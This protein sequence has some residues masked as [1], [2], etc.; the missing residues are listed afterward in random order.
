MISFVPLSAYDFMNRHDLITDHI[1][2]IDTSLSF[3]D[4]FNKNMD[5]TKRMPIMHNIVQYAISTAIYMGYKEIYLL[6]CDSTGII[7]KIKSIMH[8]S[9][10]GCYAYQIEQT[11]QR[12]INAAFDYHSIE[13]QFAGWARIF[14]LYKELYDYCLRRNI[15]LV[16]CS[17]KT[18]IEGIPQQPLN[19]VI[20]EN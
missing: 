10:D 16:N 6:G 18:I 4:H 11:D 17:S 3:Y 9:L 1:G 13:N 12:Y 8:E 20:Q 7:T 5:L 19:A 2:F 14:H 15:K